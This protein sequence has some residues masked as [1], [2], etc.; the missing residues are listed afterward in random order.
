MKNWHAC[1]AFYG[2]FALQVLEPVTWLK[3]INRYIFHVCK[4]SIQGVSEFRVQVHRDRDG[5]KCIVFAFIILQKHNV[6]L[7][8]WV[9]TNKQVFIDTRNVLLLSYEQKLSI[10]LTSERSGASIC[11][12]ESATVQLP[13]SAQTLEQCTFFLVNIRLSSHVKLLL[14]TYFR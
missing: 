1:A 3:T 5:R 9:H 6:L 11:P 7:L 12:A 2:C 14:L 8:L 4:A 10:L 13:H